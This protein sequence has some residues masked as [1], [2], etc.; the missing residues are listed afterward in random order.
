VP[1]EAEKKL[2]AVYHS[3]SN[4]LSNQLSQNILT[5]SLFRSPQSTVL[6]NHFPSPSLPRQI[7]AKPPPRR[8]APLRLCMGKGTHCPSAALSPSLELSWK[9]LEM[10]GPSQSSILAGREV[11]SQP[12]HGRNRKDRVRQ[13]RSCS[14]DQHCMA[15]MRATGCG[16]DRG[17]GTSGRSKVGGV[18]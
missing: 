10:L 12:R 2:T 4:W 1:I 3:S 18:L 16:V 9:C 8:A 11:L 5:P 15:L 6:G 14:R 13:A 17:T 7:G